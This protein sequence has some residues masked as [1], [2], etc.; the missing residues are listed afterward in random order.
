MGGA[1]Q[2]LS[3]SLSG[4]RISDFPGHQEQRCA[5]RQDILSV[6][7]DAHGHLKEKTPPKSA[8]WTK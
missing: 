2:Q 3:R 1:P 5:P 8:N 4:S 6:S 7:V